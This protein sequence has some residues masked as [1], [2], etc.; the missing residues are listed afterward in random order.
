M[1]MVPLFEHDE[2]LESPWPKPTL[3]VIEGGRLPSS[4]TRVTD[5]PLVQERPARHSTPRPSA[6]TFLRRRIAV[7]FLAAVIGFSAMAGLSSVVN[8]APQAPGAASAIPGLAMKGY[9]TVQEGDTLQSV[10][11]AVAGGAD[12]QSVKAAIVQQVGSSVVV[13]GERIAIP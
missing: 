12:V 4:P 7:G 9:Y 11:A 6:A 3:R 5:R 13:P 1:V 2:I 8:P 10:A